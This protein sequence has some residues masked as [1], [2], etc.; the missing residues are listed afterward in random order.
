MKI[1]K[2][3]L[4]A[5]LLA[6][7]AFLGV[8][9]IY[10]K[11]K[12]TS[13]IA[14]GNLRLEDEYG[15]I[16]NGNPIFNVNNM[17]PGDTED[18]DIKV[19][20]NDPVTRFISVKGNLVPASE[21]KNFSDVLTI[22]IYQ[23]TTELYP[24]KNIKKFFTESSAADGI[25]LSSVPK[26]GNATYTFKVF[27][28]SGADNAYQDAQL[29][30]DLHFGIIT[31]ESLVINEVYYDVDSNHGLE[32][33][34]ENKVKVDKQGNK[35]GINDEWVELYNPTDKEINLK[36]WTL[37]DNS[38]LNIKF[39]ARKVKPGQFVLVSKD[40]AT[41]KYWNEDREALTISTG[42]EFGDGLDN[43]GDHLTLSSP[44][45]SYTDY[46]AW[47]NLIW[48]NPPKAAEGLT[49]ERLTPGFDTDSASDWLSN[50]PPSPGK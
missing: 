13:V 10:Q 8:F 17:L 3:K 40:A 44:D 9:L 20:N 7:L 2:I 4:L 5:L 27:F 42:K 34:K 26:G 19:I 21:T 16:L 45:G 18:E 32:N 22:G 12:V 25:K 14:A 49:I 6:P 15:I 31:G 24:P 33:T 23:G 36:N 1:T 38:G 28:S 30:F 41:W 11:N 39:P 46:V 37:T 50:T 48:S 47:D 29:K 43:G 35:T